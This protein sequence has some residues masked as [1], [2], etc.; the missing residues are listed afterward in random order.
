M[1]PELIQWSGR[2]I[3]PSGLLCTLLPKC[4]I[5]SW[6]TLYISLLHKLSAW[7]SSHFFV[8]LFNK[9]LVVLE[10]IAALTCHF[11]TYV[12]IYILLLSLSRPGK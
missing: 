5:L 1:L 12:Y 9:A 11:A 10:V 2:N 4:P 3:V 6:N 7:T 8:P